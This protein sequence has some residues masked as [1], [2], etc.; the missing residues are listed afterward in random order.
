MSLKLRKQ[1][2]NRRDHR[3]IVHL[4]LL[5]ICAMLSLVGVGALAFLCFLAA[6]GLVEALSIISPTPATQ[7]I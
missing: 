7:R 4:G 6:A 1:V 2:L 3:I 5:L